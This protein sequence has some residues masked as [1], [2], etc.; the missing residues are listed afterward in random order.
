[1]RFRQHCLVV[2]NLPSAQVLFSKINSSEFIGR[3]VPAQEASVR[4]AAGPSVSDL[5]K[6]FARKEAKMQQKLGK[7]TAKL[8]ALRTKHDILLDR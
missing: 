4:G 2:V 8:G 7:I 5:D 3:P 1:M 6:R